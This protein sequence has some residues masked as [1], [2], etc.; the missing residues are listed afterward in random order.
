MK[1]KKQDNYSTFKTKLTKRFLL[2]PLI[3]IAVVI[4]F[5]LLIWQGR[6]GDMVVDFL[7]FWGF[8][9]NDALM[10][11]DYYFRG[12][13]DLFFIIAVFVLFIVLL[14][15]LFR[16][17]TEYFEGINKGIDA[18]LAENDEDIKLPEDMLPFEQKLNTVK[19]TLKQRA[20]EKQLAEKRKNE[21]VM[22]LAHDIRTPLTSIIGYLSLMAESPDIPAEQRIKY[23]NITLDK[24]Y[25]LEKMVNEF[26]E[27]TRFNSQQISISG[28]PIDLYYMLTQL[29]DE[30]TPALSGHGNSVKLDADE[31][32]SVYGDADK[33]ARVFS[34]IMKNAS[35]YSYPDTEIVVSAA[36]DEENVTIS[37]QNQGKTIPEEKLSSLFE[38]FYRLDDARTSNTGGSGLGLAIAKEIV[39]L[40]GGSI[41]ATS[42]N[43]TVTFTVVLPLST[44]AE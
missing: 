9:Y 39:T 12:N 14:R 30:L 23:M 13:R 1:I 7:Y 3:A 21:L 16:W 28:E 31:N 15:F 20:R 8:D 19:K 32:I 43:E 26:F 35:S 38:K 41:S 4:L 44:D 36:A 5:Y 11:Y 34:N 33:L 2:I 22:Y 6:G 17:I 27:I 29:L 37:F 25:R 40:H 24:S 18:L 10:T 42:E